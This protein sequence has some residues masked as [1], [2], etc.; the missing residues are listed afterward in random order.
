[1]NF[2]ELAPRK[3][4]PSAMRFEPLLPV[5]FF[6]KNDDVLGSETSKIVYVHQKLGKIPIV[7]DIFSTGLKLN[8][9]L[10]SDCFFLQTIL[11]KSRNSRKAQNTLS[12]LYWLTRQNLH[13]KRSIKISIYCLPNTKDPSK[14]STTSPSAGSLELNLWGKNTDPLPLGWIIRRARGNLCVFRTFPGLWDVRCLGPEKKLTK[15]GWCSL[16]FFSTSWTSVLYTHKKS[17]VGRDFF[18]FG[19]L[20]FRGRTVKLQGCNAAFYF[21]LLLGMKVHVFKDV[22]ELTCKEPSNRENVTYPSKTTG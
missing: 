3:N 8:H 10:V 11:K 21:A 5:M 7:P 14:S 9:Q 6:S 2:E 20:N 22:S 18:C 12:I 19:M 1:M 17:M 4:S 15:N 13:Q 16:I